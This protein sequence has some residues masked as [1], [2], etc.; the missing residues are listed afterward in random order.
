MLP[1][2][3]WQ[4]KVLFSARLAF[5]LATPLRR[6]FTNRAKVLSWARIRVGDHVLELGPGPGFFTGHLAK[7]VAPG[8]VY[9]LDVQTG[10]IAKAK[11]RLEPEGLANV[12]F[13]V[14]DAECLPLNPGAVDKV[15]AYQVL[16]EVADLNSA[17]SEIKRVLRP[18]GTL[19]IIQ[20]WFDFTPTMRDALKAIAA[21]HGLILQEESST[22]LSWKAIYERD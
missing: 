4:P 2:D 12:R 8:L 15:F 14:G 13:A 1:E 19:A 9:A 3:K 20:Y 7:K 10:M 21:A 5:L 18:K 11:M 22:R 17:I 16:E 6:L